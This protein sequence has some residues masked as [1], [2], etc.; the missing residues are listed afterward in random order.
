MHRADGRLVSNFVMQARNGEPLT[1]YGDGSQMR[2][3]CYVDG[4]IDAFIRLM[5]LRIYPD[6]PVNL[7]NPHEVSMLQ[8]AQQIGE[9]TGLE[10]GNRVSSATD[11]R[12]VA[13]AAR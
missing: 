2:P 6:G 11:R 13:S 8:I 7:G 4:M 3:F 9:I 10:V 5:N 1:V 12:P